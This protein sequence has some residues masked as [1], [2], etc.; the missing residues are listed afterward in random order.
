MCLSFA[1]MDGAAP[2][3]SLNVPSVLLLHCGMFRSSEP[4]IVRLPSPIKV[5]I[6]E[7]VPL[8]FC[9]YSVVLF[10]CF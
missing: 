2:L 1:C 4:F 9:V 8:R 10:V 6:V 5:L 3:R 7:F